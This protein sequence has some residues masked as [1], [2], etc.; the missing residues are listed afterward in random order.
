MNKVRAHNMTSFDD[1]ARMELEYID[2]WSLSLDLLIL[3]RT[4]PAVLAG[5]GAK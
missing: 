5:A 3:L 4:I 2:H 1:W